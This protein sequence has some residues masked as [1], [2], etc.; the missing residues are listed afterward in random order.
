MFEPNFVNN[1]DDT[2]TVSASCVFGCGTVTTATVTGPAVFQWR[3]GA[4]AQ[5]A[6]ADLTP[7]V[8]DALFITGGCETCSDFSELTTDDI[9]EAIDTAIDN[10]VEEYDDI[11]AEELNAMAQA[12]GEAPMDDDYDPVGYN[13]DSYIN[14][15]NGDQ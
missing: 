1:Y 4:Y 8:R 10:D 5:S 13:S 3:Q 15:L 6:F 9:D 12:F 2:Y 11:T 14:Y 7:A